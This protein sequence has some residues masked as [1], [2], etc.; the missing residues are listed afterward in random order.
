[1]SRLPVIVRYRERALDQAAIV[2][3]LALARM[4]EPG[5]LAELTG[6][7]D[8]QLVDLLHDFAFTGRKLIEATKRDAMGCAEY[9][10]RTTLFCGKESEEE[11]WDIKM[12]SL[13]EVFGRMIHSDHLSIARAHVPTASGAPAPGASAWAF[14]VSSD[15][16]RAG[17][18]NFVYIEFLIT[19]FLKFD[20]L[21]RHDIRLA[22]ILLSP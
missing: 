18:W 12:F 21:L 16:D 20:E 8:A 6:R 10:T 5:E 14:R 7:Q 19:E 15:R 4:D 22:E 3:A 9:A 11:N 2:S 13:L 17:E 1:M